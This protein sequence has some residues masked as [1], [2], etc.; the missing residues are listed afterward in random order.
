LWASGTCRV[1]GI[2]V[3]VEGVPVQICPTLFVAN[4][5]SYLD[6]VVLTRI[7]E[8]SYIAKS[9]IANWPLFGRIAKF[10]DTMFI[11]RRWR[12]ALIQ[13]NELVTRMRR[14]NSY[15]LFGEGTSTDGTVVR[16]FKSSLLSAAEP[17][18]APCPIGI[19]SVA[20]KVLEEDGETELKITPRHFAWFGDETFLPHLKRVMYA[21]GYVVAVRF[22]EHRMSWSVL[23]R[24]KL[25]LELQD[26]VAAF[27]GDAT[28]DRPAPPSAPGTADRPDRALQLVD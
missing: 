14:G 25:A 7:L 19:Q 18:V 5:L 22:G 21:R 23:D 28:A 8:A 12:D 9:E 11:H 15:I 6:I 24:K 13:R 1:L 2:R 20:L 16:K 4:H 27:A 17:W 10:G 26:E 3:V